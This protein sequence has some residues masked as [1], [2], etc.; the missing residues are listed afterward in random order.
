MSSL[1]SRKVTLVILG[2]LVFLVAC[3][4]EKNEQ[5]NNEVLATGSKTSTRKEVIEEEEKKSADD[6]FIK[7]IKS[8]YNSIE[9]QKLDEAYA[10]YKTKKVSFDEFSRWYS[11]VESIEPRAFAE[12]EPHTYRFFVDLVEKNGETTTFRVNMNVSNGLIETLSSEELQEYIDSLD[13]QADSEAQDEQEYFFDESTGQMYHYRK[14]GGVTRWPIEYAHLRTFVELQ[15]GFA[16]D[17]NHVYF[18]GI[19]IEGYKPWLKDSDPSS[20]RILSKEYAINNKAVFCFSGDKGRSLSV[21][22]GLDLE[23]V[24]VLPHSYV[25]DDKSV[26]LCSRWVRGAD[27]ATFESTGLRQ[28]RDANAIYNGEE[29]IQVAT[30]K[31]VALLKHGYFIDNKKVYFN[32]FQGHKVLPDAD[33]ETFEQINHLY[34]RDANHVYYHWSKLEDADPKTFVELGNYAKDD[35]HVYINVE[36]LPDIDA[37]SFRVLS[38][39]YFIA[40]DSVYYMRNKLPY[41]DPETFAIVDSGIARDK[42]LEYKSN[43]VQRSFSKEFLVGFFDGRTD[44]GEITFRLTGAIDDVI[45]LPEVSR[46]PLNEELCESEEV[47]HSRFTYYEKFANLE[48]GFLRGGEK[49][50]IKARHKT[51][52]F[53]CYGECPP[54]LCA[55]WK[56]IGEYPLDLSVKILP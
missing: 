35:N 48:V 4:P 6:Q 27:P 52:P 46:E 10:L 3:V 30:P 15:Y 51:S 21:I 38:G 41:A 23:K 54:T 14:E 34:S 43:Y 13:V 11:N 55:P 16:R 5:A 8:F 1:S 56:T 40:D 12:I 44:N 29:R 42:F 17:N 39:F 33:P 7:T 31:K 28:G 32:S 47:K 2:L 26:Y 19:P 50:T 25:K 9:D 22:G 45:V 18:R 36:L 49:V 24:E 20:F 53:E 37:K